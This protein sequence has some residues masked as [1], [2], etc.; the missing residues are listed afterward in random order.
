MTNKTTEMTKQTVR[1]A[2]AVAALCLAALCAACSGDDGQTTIGN[3]EASEAVASEV[4]ITANQPGTRVGFDSSGNG[5]WQEGDTI[6][7]WSSGDNTFEPFVIASGA[8]EAKATFKGKVKGEISGETVVLYP[9]HEKHT[10]TT[11]YLPD[12]YVY[13]SVDKEYSVKDGSSFR[14]PM[15][16]AVTIADSKATASFTHL[17]GVLAIKV[18]QMPSATGTVTVTSD[19]NICGNANITGG[20][21][22]TPDGGKTVTIK[23]S[24]AE[25]NTS[26]VFYLPMA[27]TSYTLKVAVANADGEVKSYVYKT[28]EVKRGHIHSLSVA[29]GYT[30]NGQKF[31]NLG[32]PSGTLWAE[33]NIGGTMPADDGGFFAWGETEAKTTFTESS[34]K[35]CDANEDITKY[36][37]STNTLEAEDD[38]ATAN[39]GAPCRIPSVADFQELVN[40]DNCSRTWQKATKSDGSVTEGFTVTSLKNGNSVFFPAAGFYDADGQKNTFT[41]GYFWTSERGELLYAEDGAYLFVIE[42]I[43]GFQQSVKL[44]YRGLSIRAVAKP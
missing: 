16:G 4:T 40:S 2:Q 13:A 38:A 23:Y 12:A 41:W 25:A 15:R 42:N 29:T 32:L 44:R 17:G 5:Y 33:V 6:A 3:A 18:E 37:D 9:Y 26:G 27:P 14:M 21:M 24:G 43:A 1:S 22:G 10:Q 34:Y 11:Y 28:I 39:W 30:I 20:T 36:T 19:T 35:W 7:V 31:V 8:G